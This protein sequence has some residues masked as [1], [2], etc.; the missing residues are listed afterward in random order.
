MDPL[1]RITATLPLTIT[2]AGKTSGSMRSSR[3]DRALWHRRHLCARPGT[4]GQG[5][6]GNISAWITAALREEQFF[7]IGE[8]N[9]A[10]R[11]KLEA[12]SRRPFQ[13]KEGSRYE[14]FRN[15]EFPLL[16]PLPVTSYELTEWK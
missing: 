16:A 2:R 12:F 9:H 1:Y 4:L 6:V 13:K 15:E 7:S 5:S 11:Q 3:N 10:I 14:I 8:L